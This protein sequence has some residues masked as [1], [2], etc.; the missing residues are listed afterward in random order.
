MAA[1]KTFVVSLLL[2]VSV[3]I[4]AP[5]VILFHAQFKRKSHH[6]MIKKRHP[7][8]LNLNGIFICLWFL[9]GFP[10]TIVNFSGIVENK[11]GNE[12]ISRIDY[13]V[14]PMYVLP[15]TCTCTFILFIFSELVWECF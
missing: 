8:I 10:F 3:L 6:I 12:I 7:Q 13:I 9:I 11:T 2:I 1:L 5:L 4:C 14:Y 15:N